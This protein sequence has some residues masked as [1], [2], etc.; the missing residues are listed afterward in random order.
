MTRNIEQQVQRLVD[1]EDI[2]ILKRRYAAFCD[3]TYNPEGIASLFTRDGIWDG[4]PLG[5][6]EGRPGIKEFFAGAPS[7]VSFAVHYTT[8]PIIEVDGDQANGS[9]Y[10]WQPMVMQGGDQAMWLAARYS[11]RYQRVD[12]RW[13]FEHVKIDVRFFSPYE[14]GWG[15]VPMAEVPS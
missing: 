2:K 3:D 12:G 8:N 13:M 6:A 14:K 10:L 15:E 1:I 5:Y 11:D 7:L 9:W 4:G